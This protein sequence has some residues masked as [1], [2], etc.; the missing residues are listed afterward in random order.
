MTIDLYYDSVK[1]EYFCI[2]EFECNNCHKPIFQ[3]MMLVNFWDKSKSWIST[4]CRQ[5]FG[6][7][8]ESSLITEHKLVILQDPP[9]TAIRIMPRPPSI[10]DSNKLTVFDVWKIISDTTTDKTIHA[11]KLTWNDAQIGDASAVNQQIQSDVVDKIMIE[12]K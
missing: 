7:F 4:Y 11:N 3:I 8:Q 9:K 1:K 12:K 5:C 2:G 6:M 10:S